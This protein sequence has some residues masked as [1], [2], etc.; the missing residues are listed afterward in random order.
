MQVI[1]LKNLHILKENSTNGCNK[2]ITTSMT[3][4]ILEKNL[5]RQDQKANLITGETECKKL[6]VGLNSS[7]AKTFR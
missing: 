7:K 2:L 1:I 3:I 5:L 6:Q 4:V